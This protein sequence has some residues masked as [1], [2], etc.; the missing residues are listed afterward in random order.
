MIFVLQDAI[1]KLNK[2]VQ[3][4]AEQVS[5]LFWITRQHYLNLN[6]LILNSA[7]GNY[8]NCDFIFF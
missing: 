5:H 6:K 8:Y 1:W 2:Q 4:H 3:S 7:Q